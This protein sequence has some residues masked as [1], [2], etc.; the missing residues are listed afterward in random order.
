M[1]QGGVF[2]LQAPPTSAVLMS[3]SKHISHRCAKV[4][5]AYVECKKKDKNPAACIKEGE[6]VTGCA[7]DL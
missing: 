3:V 4:N 5:K 2:Q 7:V 1:V 6:A